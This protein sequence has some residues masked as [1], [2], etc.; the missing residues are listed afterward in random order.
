MCLYNILFLQPTKCLYLRYLL[1]VTG[2]ASQERLFPLTQILM[3]AAFKVIIQSDPWETH[4]PGVGTT[5]SWGG[6]LNKTKEELMLS[7]QKGCKIMGYR[8][9]ICNP[10][11]KTHL[12]FPFPQ[13]SQWH[14]TSKPL[15]LFC[16][17]KKTGAE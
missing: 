1:L 7:R 9:E 10:V 6:F 13:I 3:L 4:V 15:H 17:F 14:L 16:V 11:S 5:F 2:Y 8:T 12:K